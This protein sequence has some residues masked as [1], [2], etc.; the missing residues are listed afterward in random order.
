MIFGTPATVTGTAHLG[1]TG[2]DEQ[3]AYLLRGPDGQLSVLAAAIRTRTPQEAVLI[4]SE[5]SI[6]L[7]PPWWHSTGLT[8]SRHG[9]DDEVLELPYEGNGYNYEAAH[10][11]DC[12]R[13]GKLDSDVMPLDETLSVTETMDTLRSQWG[14]TYPAE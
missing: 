10:V 6:R 3:S 4:G 13:A 1:Q 11:G 14:L 2:V 8:V 7:H 5:G 12:L 9:K